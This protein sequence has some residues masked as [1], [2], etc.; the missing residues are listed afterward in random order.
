MVQE[1]IRRIARESSESAYRWDSE[2][3]GEMEIVGIGNSVEC[4]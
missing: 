2:G 4:I 3:V 1:I